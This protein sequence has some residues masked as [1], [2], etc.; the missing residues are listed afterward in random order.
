[1]ARLLTQTLIRSQS[2]NQTHHR[3]FSSQTPKTQL[4]E[5]DLDSSSS[6][7][8]SD[9]EV[10]VLGI[11]KLEDAIH[12]LIVKQSKPDW[13][14]FVPG[15]S[16]WVPPRIQHKK[17]SAINDVFN[18]DDNV[19]VG[20]SAAG[21]VGL[22]ARFNENKK[23]QMILNDDEFRLVLNKGWPSYS[24]FVQGTSTVQSPHVEMEAEVVQ[25]KEENVP[26]T[27]NEEG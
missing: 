10:E 27:K 19:F 24:Y 6:S 4:I 8:S 11:R 12:S 1:M 15:S 18:D 14:P 5:I 22:L 9:T 17:I 16:Y 2:I 25:S 20:G 23:Q 26:D 3:F 21:I 13:I 7:S